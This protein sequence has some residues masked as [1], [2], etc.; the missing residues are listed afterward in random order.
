MSDG[1][2]GHL[3]KCFPHPFAGIILSRLCGCNLSPLQS[4]PLIEGKCRDKIEYGNLKQIVGRFESE[5]GWWR[6]NPAYW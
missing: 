6:K 2:I 3:K 5:K 4:T 1:V